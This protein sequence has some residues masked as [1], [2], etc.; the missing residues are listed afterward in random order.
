[1]T[2]KARALRDVYRGTC[3]QRAEIL[4]VDPESLRHS[5]EHLASLASRSRV[6]DSSRINVLRLGDIIEAASDGG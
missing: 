2:A 1:M 5:S 3:C 4:P 6:R